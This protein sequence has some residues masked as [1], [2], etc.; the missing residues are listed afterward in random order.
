MNGSPAPPPGAGSGGG[1]APVFPEL[2]GLALP[3]IIQTLLLNVTLVVDR[4]LIGRLGADA[5][6]GIDL[7]FRIVFFLM[8]ILTALAAGASVLA[9]QARGAGNEATLRAITTSTAQFSIVFGGILG[10]ALGAWPGP[11]LD[12]LGAPPGAREEAMRFLRVLAP[13]GPALVWA[14]LAGGILRAL[15][16][17][18]GPLIIAVASGVLNTALNFAW[19]FGM[20]AS[21]WSFPALGTAG[22]ALAM[23][24]SQAASALLLAARVRGATGIGRRD[25][26]MFAPAWFRRLALLGIPITLDVLAWQ[27]GQ[28]VFTRIVA[29]LG[30]TA[31]AARAILEIFFTQSFILVAGF[32]AATV[33]LCGQALGREDF[34]RARRIARVGL[35]STASTMIA[36][37]IILGLAHAWILD[38]FAVP[39]AVRADAVGLVALFILLHPWSVPNG[40]VPFVLRSGGDTTA[41]VAI[42][43]ATMALIG[44][45]LAWF[46]AYPMQ[47]GVLGAY[48]GFA[49]HDAVKGQVFLAR[50]RM[51]RWQRKLI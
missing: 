34:A 16:D 15:K 36:G 12:L 48:A 10:L 31:V 24:V 43:G 9:A 21:G 13:A 23:A 4:V 50:L 41:I 39:A 45:P 26:G 47:G 11:I 18:K 1:D 22:A 17:T 8:V 19:I 14:N 32:S 2:L 42:T 38:L 7:A 40:V 3:V 33:T 30:S 20:E 35:L 49:I 6:G 27:A 37:V 25:L 44:L 28:M 46:L 51:G 29:G 5:L